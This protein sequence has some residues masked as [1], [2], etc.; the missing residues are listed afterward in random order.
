M[1][2]FG[3]HMRFLR[4]KYNKTLIEQANK[5][6]VSVAYLSALE[7]GK[8]GKPTPILIDQICVWLGLIWDEAEKLKR[9]AQISH[10]KPVINT[11]N[12]GPRATALGNMLANNIDRLSENQCSR[13]GNQL[14][15]ML[16]AGV[17]EHDDK[18]L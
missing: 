4:S 10:P 6:A 16:S 3:E 1:T 13:L 14:E 7:H 5:L 17:E 11:S 8:R 2:P 12:L 15:Q 9:L 18:N